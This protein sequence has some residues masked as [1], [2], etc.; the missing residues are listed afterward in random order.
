[1]EVF[2]V[3]EYDEYGELLEPI[4]DYDPTNRKNMTK[5]EREQLD[6]DCWVGYANEQEFN[7]LF[8]SSGRQT[9]EHLMIA[10][11]WAMSL[12]DIEDN[13]GDSERLLSSLDIRTI[14]ILS[15][16]S[17]RKPTL[18][19]EK[20]TQLKNQY[21]KK[22]YKAVIAGEI[23]GFIEWK[24]WEVDKWRLVMLENSPESI[25]QLMRDQK[26]AECKNI[27]IH[28]YQEENLIDICLNIYID[29]SDFLEWVS[30]TNDGITETCLLSLWKGNQEK[31][32]TLETMEIKNSKEYKRSK[33]MKDWFEGLCKDMGPSDAKKHIMDVENRKLICELKSFD[34]AQSHLWANGEALKTFGKLG[35]EVWGFKKNGGRRV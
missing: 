35:E 20:Y 16:D 18:T 27:A 24:S 7:F 3:D 4:D 25:K 14:S 23:N 32:A 6:M 34:P 13:L 5:S 10:E 19:Y 29:R 26:I 9:L 12:E 22:I 15:A 17:Q 2:F 28:R 8:N 21:A 31:Q 30:K 33:I 1:M 11:A